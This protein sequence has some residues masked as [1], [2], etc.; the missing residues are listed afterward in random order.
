[1]TEANPAAK[2]L[3]DRVRRL[4]EKSQKIDPVA[5]GDDPRV[6]PELISKIPSQ[7]VGAN[8]AH[9]DDMGNNEENRNG[10]I[11]Q[12][13]W[14]LDEMINYKAQLRKEVLLESQSPKFQHPAEKLPR[15][16]QQYLDAENIRL[17]SHQA[18]SL[19][20]FR[21]HKNVAL[22]TQTA[23]GK[24]L[25]FNLP[26]LEVLLSNPSSSAI[27]LYPAKALAN[28]QLNKLKEFDE[29]FSLNSHPASYDG[30]TPASE[31]KKIK[32][33][34]RVIVT[35]P[36]GLHIYLG[37]KD[38]W[39]RILRNL[40]VV[41]VD[42][43]HYY[44]G[45]VGSHMAMVVRRLRRLAAHYGA[46]PQFF[47]ASATIANP[48]EHAEALTGVDF[49]LVA[50]DGGGRP[51]R[52]I[53]FWDTQKDLDH[54]PT[55]QAAALSRHLVRYDRQLIV[56]S[57]TRH[58]AEMIAKSASDRVHRVAAYRAG[59]SP[60][61]RRS[62]ELDLKEGRLR[63]VSSTS[64]LELGVDIGGVDTVI[65]NGM[66][67]SIASFWQRAGRAGRSGQTST[68]VLM[69]GADPIGRFILNHP[70]RLLDQSPEEAI[71]NPAN[72][73][74][75]SQHLVCAA[76]ELPLCSGDQIY[77]G[78]GFNEAT[79]DLLTR[80]DLVKDDEGRLIYTRKGKPQFGVSLSGGAEASYSLEV[81]KDSKLKLLE[82]LPAQRAMREAH[83][84]AIYHHQGVAYRIKSVN[85]KDLK[86]HAVLEKSS[87]F[88]VS[89]AIKSVI[90]DP[91]SSSF[92]TSSGIEIGWGR[93]NVIEAVVGFKE[94]SFKGT[95]PRRYVVDFPSR[96]YATETLAI[97]FNENLEL[98]INAEG[99]DP[100]LGAHSAEH[101][102]SKVLPLLYISDRRDFQSMSLK[103]QG[104]PII[105]LY[106]LTEGGSGVS[107]L[108]FNSLQRLCDNAIQL[109]DSCG[110]S[111][112]CPFCVLDA[113][114]KNEEIDKDLGMGV[115]I[116]LRDELAKTG[117]SPK[118]PATDSLIPYGKT[119][120]EDEQI[121]NDFTKPWGARPRGRV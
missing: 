72:R 56:F 103:N 102:I 60:H 51:K 42:E 99:T 95:E 82:S 91:P 96:S 15:K 78:D 85:H 70:E 121:K 13:L 67:S 115:L 58:Q 47:V 108:A 12:A 94:Y 118:L 100:Y 39:S 113:S 120:T 40:K 79:E 84:G 38:G 87:N 77:F 5:N 31:R 110:C 61:D 2:D 44:S 53:V 86:I 50:K 109:V 73:P 101:A 62:I 90:F 119:Q 10:P 57:D 21:D 34:S 1:M 54:S 76:S 45:D 17:Y 92:F 52:W 66:P 93:A 16:I 35:N 41:V 112:G 32:E 43:A 8:N 37:W 14:E 65:L 106:D 48:K 7:V 68:V 59:F 6:T 89:A 88:T 116:F 46:H 83:V 33:T 23:S 64:A 107:K 28:D 22:A 9:R 97:G 26:I 55:S 19:N 80:N 36:H 11:S 18:D 27:Y 117:D 3:L 69:T 114:C 4:K 20:L 75:L 111:A 104:S 25:A 29:K 98:A 105:A 74:I 30:D 71:V 81:E 24:S 63:G 49:E